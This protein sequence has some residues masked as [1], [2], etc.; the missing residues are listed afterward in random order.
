MSAALPPSVLGDDVR[1]YV[2]DTASGLVL[3]VR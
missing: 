1:A 3:T 2:S